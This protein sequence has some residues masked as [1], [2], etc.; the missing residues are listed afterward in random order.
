MLKKIQFSFAHLYIR[1][2]TCQTVQSFLHLILNLLSEM[3]YFL[4][5]SARLP[6]PVITDCPQNSS[7]PQCV[8]SCSVKNGSQGQTLSLY[9]KH[10]VVDIKSLS[11]PNTGFNLSQ[12]V[13]CQDK[14]IYSCVVSNSL[15]NKTTQFNST[16]HCHYSGIMINVN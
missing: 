8:L 13:D 11:D 10:S 14:N 5:F 2:S 15:T 16:H 7:N 1:M 12:E 9:K 3:F 6:D 4:C